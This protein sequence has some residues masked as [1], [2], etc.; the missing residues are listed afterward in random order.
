MSADTSD[1]AT[2]YVMAHA[3]DPN[4]DD[5]INARTSYRPI[6]FGSRKLSGAETRYFATERELLGLVYA[7]KKN[8][9]L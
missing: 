4:D 3:A 6:L 1:I 7:L 5:N 8:E 2:G 9:H